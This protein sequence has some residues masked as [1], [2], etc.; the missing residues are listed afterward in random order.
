MPFALHAGRKSFG[1][2]CPFGQGKMGLLVVVGK[3]LD[4]LQ[5]RTEARTSKC[6]M[7]QMVKRADPDE[8]Y[9]VEFVKPYPFPVGLKPGEYVRVLGFENGYYRVR[10][11]AGQEFEVFMLCVQTGS[12]YEEDNKWLE[13]D[14][15]RVTAERGREKKAVERFQKWKHMTPLLQELEKHLTKVEPEEVI[16]IRQDTLG[17]YGMNRRKMMEWLEERG[18]MGLFISDTQSIEARRR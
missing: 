8:W 17:L 12:L 2:N 9:C 14:D 10:D 5:E 6:R 15:P 7:Q 18:F 1:E 3:F 11:K 4:T 13:A 16:T